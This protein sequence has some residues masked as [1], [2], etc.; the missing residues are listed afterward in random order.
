M[1]CIRPFIHSVETYALEEYE[2]CF[3]L[4]ELNTQENKLTIQ[5]NVYVSEFVSV[6][7]SIYKH[8]FAHVYEGGCGSQTEPA[9]ILIMKC[10]SIQFWQ[11]CMC[12]YEWEWECVWWQCLFSHQDTEA[13]SWQ[14]NLF[15]QTKS[16]RCKFP[17]PEKNQSHFF[18]R[19]RSHF[20]VHIAC[21][22]CDDVSREIH[23]F[24]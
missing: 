14:K 7:V 17:D 11:I 9:H 6:S 22:L 19:D 3:T 18:T 10:N 20:Q 12:S 23:H 2:K 21:K 13:L 4:I 5:L 16:S 24:R 1:S 15:T 8:V